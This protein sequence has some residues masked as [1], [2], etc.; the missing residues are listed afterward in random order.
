MNWVRGIFFLIA[1]NAAGQTAA[2]GCAN[3][4]FE[5]DRFTVCT[6]APT[7]DLR[8]FHSGADGDNYG[9]FDTL[10]DDLATTGRTLGFAMN[11]AM[12]HEDRRP[13]GHY[14]EN[15]AELQGLVTREGPGNFGLL[16]NG[17]FCI[18][19]AANR[20]IETKTYDAARPSCDYAMQ[21]GPMLVIDGAL[22]PRFNAESTSRKFRNGV[23][24]A[25]DGTTYFAISNN[26]VNF[27]SFGRL[28]RDVLQT[29]NALFIDGTISRLY[30]PDIGRHDK[31]AEMGPIVGTVVNR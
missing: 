15:G 6:I 2:S 23:G 14:I 26:S 1:A 19:D 20:V 13:V 8:L 30:A 5:G 18:G 4:T 7:D 17:V 10:I 29:P 31:G 24:V 22:H 3:T 28:F 16:P 11:G 12:Y 25:D 9:Q 27:H 21:S